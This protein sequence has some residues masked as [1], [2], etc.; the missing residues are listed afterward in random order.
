MPVR[1]QQ[2]KS[3]R[4]QLGSSACSGQ[5]RCKGRWRLRCSE[6]GIKGYVWAAYNGT[7]GTFSNVKGNCS[8]LPGLMAFSKVMSEGARGHQTRQR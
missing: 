4:G 5:R 6:A 3:E 1:S 7:K 8:A 2:G